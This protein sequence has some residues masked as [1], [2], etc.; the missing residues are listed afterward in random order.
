[1]IVIDVDD[2]GKVSGDCVIDA[3]IPVTQFLMLESKTLENLIQ[4]TRTLSL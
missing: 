4:A 1:V 3:R 2:V